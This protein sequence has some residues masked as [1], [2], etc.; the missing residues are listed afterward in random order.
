MA[1]GELNNDSGVMSVTAP[2]GGYTKGSVYLINDVYVVALETKAAGAACLVCHR[3]D[4]IEVSKNAGTGISFAFGDKVYFKTN[5]LS[6]ATSTG[7]V[8]LNAMALETAAAAAT[9]VKIALYGSLAPT[10]T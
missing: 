7:A 4:C 9:S 8:L 5:K 3:A 2:T 6:A 1:A 10:A